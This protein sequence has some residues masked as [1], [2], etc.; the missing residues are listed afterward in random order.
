MNLIDAVKS[1][2]P[3]KRPDDEHWAVFRDGKL[4][5]CDELRNEI[6]N[7]FMREFEDFTATDYILKDE[8]K[9]V[10]TVKM[11]RPMEREHGN[12]YKYASDLVFI[13]KTRSIVEYDVWQVIEVEV[14]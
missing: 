13:D 8:P 12:I 11:Y 5:I 1:G 4:F 6:R 2:K 3:F 7:G 14:E 10:K 9:K